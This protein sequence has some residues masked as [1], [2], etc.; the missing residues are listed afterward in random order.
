[1]DGLVKIDVQVLIKTI[2]Y[3]ARLS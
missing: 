3:I 2:P 1:M